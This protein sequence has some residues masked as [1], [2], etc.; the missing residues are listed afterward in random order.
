MSPL[1]KTLT[2]LLIGAVLLFVGCGSSSNPNP[3]N[4]NTAQAQQLGGEAFTDFF[5]A[6][7]V[8]LQGSASDTSRKFSLRAVLPKNRRISS[9]PTPETVSCSGSSCTI[10]ATYTCLDGGSIGVS[11]SATENGSSSASLNITETPTNCSDGTL[12]INGDPD[13][14]LKGQIN[15]NGTTTSVSIS[16]GGGISFSP[17]TAGQ[18]PTGSCKSNLQINV[19]ITDSSSTETSCSISGSI[20]G[21]AMNQNC[22]PTS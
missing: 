4:L 16:I 12:V 8:A 15:N 20:C 14:T 21:V 19:S 1:T 13:V 11:G 2:V 7:E 9:A 6:T 5:S 3:N 17:V 22:L 10:T 18:F